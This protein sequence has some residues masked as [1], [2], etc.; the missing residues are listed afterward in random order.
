MDKKKILFIEDNPLLAD[1]YA[2]A[3]ASDE[4]EPL[5]AH[6]GAAGFDLACEHHPDLVVLDVLMPGVDG[7]S[8]LEMI[9]NEERTSSCR[10]VV[11]TS[12]TKEA[13][14]EQMKSLGIE[15]YIIKTGQELPDIIERIKKHL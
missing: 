15:D 13:T 6:D 5:L 1:M 7:V 9:R 11:L 2:T 4:I 14:I 10:V 8:A 12:I 3:M